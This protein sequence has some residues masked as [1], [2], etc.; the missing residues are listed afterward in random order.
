MATHERSCR[1]EEEE[2]EKHFLIDLSLLM[3]RNDILKMVLEGSF[4]QFKEAPS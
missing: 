1:K 3:F 4:R 2:E